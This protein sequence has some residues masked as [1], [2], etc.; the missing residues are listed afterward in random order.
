MPTCTPTPRTLAVGALMP[1]TRCG[2]AWVRLST[3][4]TRTTTVDHCL[5]WQHSSQWSS[6]DSQPLR[7]FSTVPNHGVATMTRQLQQ[8]YDTPACFILRSRPYR[9]GNARRVARSRPHTTV[10]PQQQ[11]SDQR[12]PSRRL[13]TTTHLTLVLCTATPL[14][15]VALLA[16]V[17]SLSSRRHNQPKC[18]S[19]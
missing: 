14:Y 16:G 5:L 6:Q 4:T 10:F 12:S 18:A 1:C 9:A 8:R 17:L 2:G 11:S 3:G 19:Y 13:D 15:Q 7:L